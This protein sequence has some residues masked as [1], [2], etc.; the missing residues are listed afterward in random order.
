MGFCLGMLDMVGCGVVGDVE[1]VG[2]GCCVLLQIFP[3]S[4]V[5]LALSLYILAVWHG[6]L[7]NDDPG[8]KFSIY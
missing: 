1:Q 2:V 7:V 6:S 5:P 8:D 4:L 3:G